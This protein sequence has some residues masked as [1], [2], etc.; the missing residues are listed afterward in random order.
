MAMA[1]KTKHKKYEVN[2]EEFTLVWLDSDISKD[3]YNLEAQKQLRSFINHF[4]PFDNVDEC[5]KYMTHVPHNRYLVFI[6]SGQL[7]QDIV[8]RIHHIH[9]VFSIYIFCQNKPLHEQWAKQ[10]KKVKIFHI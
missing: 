9:Q 7:G 8:P 3:K 10:H 6:V 1:Y 5:R 2:L 4:K